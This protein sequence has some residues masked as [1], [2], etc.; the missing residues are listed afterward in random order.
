MDLGIADA[1]LISLPYGLD[2][3]GYIACIE[4]RKRE[5]MKVRACIGQ[6]LLHI[7]LARDPEGEKTVSELHVSLGHSCCTI[8]FWSSGPQLL[9]SLR[10]DNRK[11]GSSDLTTLLRALSDRAFLG[12][13]DRL[14]RALRTCDQ[15]SAGS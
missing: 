7:T 3:T 13:P 12:R 11:T 8:S 1:L 14:G 15:H 6:T 2:Y 10:Y 5:N 9:H 4:L